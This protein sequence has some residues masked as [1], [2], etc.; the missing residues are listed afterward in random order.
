M[1]EIMA[2]LTIDENPVVRLENPLLRVDVAPGVGGRIVSV[3]EKR[4]GHAFL[5]HNPN[6]RLKRLAPGSE[7]DPN[8]YGGIDDLIPNDFPETVD[9]IAYPDHGELWTTALSQRIEQEALVL[10][11]NLPLIRLH[12]TKRV[13][14]RADSPR[15]DLDYRVENRSGEV[16]RFMWKLHAA[17]DVQPGDRIVCPARTARVADLQWS[18]WRT[19][20]PFAWPDLQGNRVDR[21]PAANGTCDFFYLYDLEAGRLSWERPSRS[22]R[23]GLEFDPAVF[24]FAW[25][26]ASYGGLLGYY[27][28]VLEPCSG[29]PM[30]V[31]EAAAL[32]QCSVLE[33]GQSIETRVSIYAGVA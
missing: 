24:P 32:G 25:V 17:L 19:L 10:E 31:N 1:T 2:G 28:V 20:E 22:L 27:T 30:S 29:M 16:R 26:F 33:P 15:I 5:W 6:L 9:G 14:L 7:Y 23:L 8:F 4:S 18:R 11:G 3:V 13:G 12:Y 21:V